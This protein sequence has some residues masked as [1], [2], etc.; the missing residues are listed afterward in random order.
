[1]GQEDVLMH[2]P[3]ANAAKLLD[4]SPSAL[5]NPCV[6]S[7]SWCYWDQMMRGRSYVKARTAA[8]AA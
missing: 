1:V 2:V 3:L 5:A 8:A 6:W 4:F 7:W